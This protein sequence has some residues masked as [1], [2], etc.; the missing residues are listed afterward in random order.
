MSDNSNCTAYVSKIGGK[1]V[2][3]EKINAYLPHLPFTAPESDYSEA[4]AVQ[5][6]PFVPKKVGQRIRESFGSVQAGLVVYVLEN[7][8]HQPYVINVVLKN[9]FGAWEIK[10][11]PR[12]AAC[13]EVTYLFN[14]SSKDLEL[15]TLLTDPDVPPGFGEY[16]V[17]HCSPHAGFNWTA[18][19]C[20]YAL[21]SHLNG[22][23]GGSV[24]ISQN[25]T[26]TDAAEM[27]TGLRLL[28]RIAREKDV[29]VSLFLPVLGGRHKKARLSEHCSEYVTV[30]SCEPDIGQDYA[31]SFDCGNYRQLG[32]LGLPK[33]M[34]SVQFGPDQIAYSLDPFVST[35][36][37]DRIIWMM[38]AQR[39]TF[40]E[41][42][43]MFKKHKS[44][45]LHR[46]RSVRGPDLR[47]VDQAWLE[48]KLAAF[49]EFVQ[50][51]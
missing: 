13:A 11:L 2:N 48:T 42:G 36:L 45:I 43:L 6:P 34:C 1:P 18:D 40:E 9:T 14:G 7:V 20:G 41:I 27:V 33:M 17:A 29:L 46:L 51:E 47:D 16:K 5:T 49:S 31:F 8:E 3:R 35:Q 44:T 28:D 23:R 50:R 22:V 38:R 10:T 12:R 19:G 25:H 30:Q 4:E 21:A 15:E 26:G 37:D 39:K 24:I 32:R